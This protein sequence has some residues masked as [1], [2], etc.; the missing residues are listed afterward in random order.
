MTSQAWLY[1]LLP[2]AVI[3][4]GTLAATSA[5]LAV[6]DWACVEPTDT[7][8][9]TV[10]KA[11]AAAMTSAGGPLGICKEAAQPGSPVKLYVASYVSAGVTGLGA[12]VV[13]P[14]KVNTTTARSER[15][16]SPVV[17]DYLVGISDTGGGLTFDF[18]LPGL[19]AS[20]PTATNPTDDGKMLYAS[21]G[22]WAKTSTVTAGADFISFGA[23]PAETGAI[24][25][26]NGSANGIYFESSPAAADVTGMYL[27]SSETLRLLD[28]TGNLIA[29]A[30]SS[31]K[32]Q[33]Q[34][35]DHLVVTSG[36]VTLDTAAL[37]FGAAPATAGQIRFSN[38]ATIQFRN[39]ANTGDLIGLQV[40]VLDQ[41]VFGSSLTPGMFYNV[42]AG[43]THSV[44]VGGA[45]EYV[46]SSSTAQFLDNFQTFT[47]G[48]IRFGTNP[49][50]G[51]KLNVA[52]NVSILE[53]RN[54][55]NSADLGLLAVDAS[56]ILTVGHATAGPASAYYAVAASGQHRFYINN[57]NEYSFDET[58]FIVGPGNALQFNTGAVGVG[59]LIN[60]T[61]TVAFWVAR[62]SANTGNITLIDLGS[63]NNL[64]LGA[65]TET[66][67]AV[68]LLC[69]SAGTIKFSH[70]GTNRIEANADGLGF[71]AVAPVA[72]Q[73]V[74]ALSMSVGTA[75]G[76]VADVGAAFNQ[77][78]LNN[79]FRDVGERVN[80]MRTAL[81]NLGL[82]S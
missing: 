40:N 59:G 33:R 53:A 4:E 56:D 24:R 76:T 34:G 13:Q 61:K 60:T 30:S 38:N 50:T 6:G 43:N 66:N 62:N 35:V 1:D 36:A 41:L 16:A 55:A 21:A 3:W 17:G 29:N 68:N 77:T 32:L 49:A 69:G 39:V 31:I 74:T 75:D 22:V 42:A 15:V 65:S 64:L 14:V 7:S 18:E 63:A 57:A 2:H 37:V 47:T 26:S 81:V 45:N 19:S 20:V 78:T 71:F 25:L 28:G 23:D 58:T 8:G 67:A 11:V 72:R 79:N 52:N 12:G 70:N 48:E 73:A 9:G 82:F 5:A 80:A 10:T 51:A 27:D 46:F 44:R 54:A